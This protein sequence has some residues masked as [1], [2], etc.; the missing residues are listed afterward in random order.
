MS[1]TE[2]TSEQAIRA[3]AICRGYLCR[4]HLKS[5]K[6]ISGFKHRLRV[7]EEIIQTEQHY[8]NKLVVL[9]DYFYE[10]L[11]NLRGVAKSDLDAIFG[12]VSTIL[13][14]NMEFLHDLEQRWQ[15]WPFLQL[16]GDSFAQMAPYLRVYALYVNN[17]NKALLTVSRLMS[18]NS[19]FAHFINETCQR[20]EVNESSF[21]SILIIPAQRIPRYRLLLRDLLKYTPEAHIDRTN[22]EE[23]LN[24]ISETAAFINQRARDAENVERV[25]S[26]QSHLGGR[27]TLIAPHRKFVR[28][29]P[30]SEA[31]EGRNKN[32]GILFNDIL[33]LARKSSE[34][35]YRARDIVGLPLDTRL[36]PVDDTSFE[37]HGSECTTGAAIEPTATPKTLRLHC[38]T[39]EDREAW[40]ATIEA[41]VAE[42]RA[43]HEIKALDD[44][45]VFQRLDAEG[46]PAPRSL[47]T[48]VSHSG[49][50]WVFGG[51]DFETVFGDLA[52]YDPEAR[53]WEHIEAQG[54][55][56]GPRAQHTLVAAEGMFLLFGGTDVNGQAT[57]D[58][59]AFD[60]E[61][62]A[63]QAVQA[64]GDVPPPLYGH[65]ACVHK[66]NVVVFGG[67][68]GSAESNE[69]YTLN[70][71]HALW[72]KKTCSG[73]K[74][75]PRLSHA[76]G[77]LGNKL[78]IFGGSALNKSYGDLHALDLGNYRWSTP[79]TRSEG[80]SARF[81]MSCVTSR[82][83]FILFG[84]RTATTMF[85]DV[86][87]L[88]T[89]NLVWTRESLSGAVPAPSSAHAAALFE[90]RMYIFGGEEASGVT[91]AAHSLCIVTKREEALF[92]EVR[93]RAPQA[94][95]RAEQTFVFLSHMENAG[96]RKST[97][98]RS[99]T[100]HEAS[101]IQGQISKAKRFQTLR[102]EHSLALASPERPS[103]PPSDPTDPNFDPTISPLPPLPS[104]DA[105]RR[106]SARTLSGPASHA[107][108]VGAKTLPSPSSHKP[109]ATAADPSPAAQSTRVRDLEA[110]NARL[111]EENRR[112]REEKGKAEAETGRL[113][114][115]EADKIRF[116]AERRRLQEEN[117]RLKEQAQKVQQEHTR[118]ATALDDLR[119]QLDHAQAE[120]GSATKLRDLTQR[121]LRESEQ[122]LHEAQQRVA[123]APKALCPADID[124]ALEAPPPVPPRPQI[125][126]LFR[127]RGEKWD[128]LID[129]PLDDAPSSQIA[130][131]ASAARPPILSLGALRAIVRSHHN[132]DLPVSV[133]TDRGKLRTLRT[134][135]EL[136]A[137]FEDYQRTNSPSVFFYV[138]EPGCCAI[139]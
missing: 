67:R 21:Q 28:D 3:Q 16:I 13:Q 19:A 39:P 66:S 5:S 15:N 58:L 106:R 89:E 136:D 65:S 71:E 43:S 44:S 69:V 34:T 37:L 97:K 135:E 134:Q 115:L 126:L 110:A 25:F 137:V 35:S 50:L 113:R 121:R 49:K 20:P 105:A 41:Q 108:L 120:L 82:K 95:A 57:N 94:R 103:L 11:K 107:L 131:A 63:W 4:R 40:V 98:Y 128:H 119:R 1:E 6:E 48:M 79:Q 60:P 138:T 75:A 109:N 124:V 104:K 100:E 59:R 102:L 14:F 114:G 88:D 23:A 33:I 133:L 92:R 78:Y 10:P 139:M 29:G 81:C 129:A 31:A 122:A 2:S 70:I 118:R 46:A 127:Y 18:K 116:E 84:G 87:R 51:D 42:R 62:R 38:E 56:P 22:I 36:E 90:K 91:A 32:W 83:H 80:P 73:I 111:V 12:E 74:P 24:Q 52:V 64:S 72:V 85:N 7:V 27:W 130:Q 123:A 96:T 125:R 47:H 45:M 93:T 8:V 86:Y 76:A 9:R 101:L 112:L 30:L 17:Y 61:S 77:I 54:D 68:A 26:Y 99:R 117:Q 132:A 55:V 53:A